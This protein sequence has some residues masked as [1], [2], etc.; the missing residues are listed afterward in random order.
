MSYQDRL[1]EYER[2]K[3]KLLNSGMTA[4]EYQK[5]IIALA[6]KWKV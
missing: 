6:K 2:E 1:Y 5:A 4:A 3:K